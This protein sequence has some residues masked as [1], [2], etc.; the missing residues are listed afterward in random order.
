MT[1]R[2]K[3]SFLLIEKKSLEEL[4]NWQRISNQSA[5]QSANQKNP[6]RRYTATQSRSP[7][8]ITAARDQTQRRPRFD[9]MRLLPRT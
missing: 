3:Q 6:I 7:I 4:R 2:L 1:P 5:E 8:G 9:L